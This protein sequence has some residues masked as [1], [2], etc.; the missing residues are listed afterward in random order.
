LFTTLATVGVCGVVITGGIVTGIPFPLPNA[1]VLI[2]TSGGLTIADIAGVVTKGVG[3]V[4]VS[5]WLNGVTFFT[6]AAM[7]GV[8]G[9][10]VFEIGVTIAI[11]S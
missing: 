3:D 5:I 2:F 4:P 8:T 1:A 11:G 10:L 7:G 9:W 6:G